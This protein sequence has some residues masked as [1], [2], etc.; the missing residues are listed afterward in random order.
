[1]A[2]ILVVGKERGEIFYLYGAHQTHYGG[3]A[4]VMSG[5]D[6]RRGRRVRRA[7]GNEA[8]EGEYDVR[9]GRESSASSA[10]C[11]VVLGGARN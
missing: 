10:W 1:M 2:R 11:R 9:G 5:G 3:V 7:L 6:V 4:D 8:A